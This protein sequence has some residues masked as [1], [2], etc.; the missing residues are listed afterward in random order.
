M[1]GRRKEEGEGCWRETHVGHDH[2]FAEKSGHRLF[3]CS[4]TVN[5]KYQSGIAH[6]A[7]WYIQK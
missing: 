6:V 2:S 1:G 5:A 4:S 3:D 7:R